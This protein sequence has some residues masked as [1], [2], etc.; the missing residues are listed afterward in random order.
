MTL[1]VSPSIMTAENYSMCDNSK[2]IVG[3]AMYGKTI[4][5]ND[6]KEHAF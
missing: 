1:S 4:S 6:K 2:S 3:R 5:Q